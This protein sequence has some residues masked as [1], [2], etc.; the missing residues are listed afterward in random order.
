MRSVEVTNT[1]ESWKDAEYGM[2]NIRTEKEVC[3]FHQFTSGPSATPLAIVENQ[4]GKV[5]S[6]PLHA[7]RFL[8]PANSGN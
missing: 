2:P 5:Y 6:V 1:I 4:Q 8:T 3:L 7:I